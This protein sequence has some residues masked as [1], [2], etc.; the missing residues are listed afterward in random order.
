MRKRGVSGVLLKIQQGAITQEEG[1]QQI[2]LLEEIHCFLS[3][4]YVLEE[5]K[6]E[7]F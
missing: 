4:N 3:E 7:L 6:S 1:M 5:L 2:A